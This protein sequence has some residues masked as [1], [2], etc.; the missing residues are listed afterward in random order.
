MQRRFLKANPS[1]NTLESSRSAARVSRVWPANIPLIYLYPVEKIRL[2]TVRPFQM[3]ETI[4]SRDLP[5][6][7]GAGSEKA[8]MRH[9]RTLVQSLLDTACS[10][11]QALNPGVSEADIPRPLIRVKASVFLRPLTCKKVEYSG[12]FTTFN[13]QQFGREFVGMCV[14]TCCQQI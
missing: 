2:K 11:Y 12:G 3:A 5:Q 6:D 9:L 4:L 8:V 13:P 1:R 14:L 10:E 7:T